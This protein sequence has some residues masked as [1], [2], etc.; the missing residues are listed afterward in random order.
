MPVI[1]RACFAAAGVAA[2]LW[3]GVVDAAYLS[4]FPICTGTIPISQT[5]STDLKTFTNKGYICAVVI[6]SGD[7]ENISLVYGTGTTC[8]TGTAALIG[9]TTA[10]T[11]MPISPN[12]G[13]APSSINLVTATT[14]QHLCLLQSGTGRVAGVITYLDAP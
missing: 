4:G 12:G 6:V 3:A 13:I 11:G 9:G 8:G 10:A 14:A 7:A 2:G 1:R 5:A